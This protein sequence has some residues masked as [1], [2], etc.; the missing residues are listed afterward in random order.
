LAHLRE[1]FNRTLPERADAIAAAFD[2]DGP[3]GKECAALVHQMAGI[4]SNLG[5]PDITQ[6]AITA[7]ESLRTHGAAAA[8]ASHVAAL[9]AAMRHR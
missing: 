6:L 1:E 8:A 2:S 5:R 3:R 4:A 7:E 9:V